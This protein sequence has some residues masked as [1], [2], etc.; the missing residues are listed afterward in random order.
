MCY[1]GEFIDACCLNVLIHM[2]FNLSDAKFLTWLL[3]NC[4]VG[5][6]AVSFGRRQSCNWWTEES[7]I[8]PDRFKYLG[9]SGDYIVQNGQFDLRNLWTN[10]SCKQWHIAIW[11]N[12]RCWWLSLLLSYFFL[13]VKRSNRWSYAWLFVE[14]FL[15]DIALSCFDGESD[16]VGVCI[17]WQTQ[18]MPFGDSWKLQPLFCSLWTMREQ[19]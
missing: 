10:F 13:L 4:H 6:T 9:F 15:C 12:L 19:G 8:F 17:G 18:T 11:K 3:L 7:S 16:Y 2:F 5:N 14:L 1:T